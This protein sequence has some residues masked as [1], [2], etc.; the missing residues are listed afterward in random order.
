MKLPQIHRGWIFGLAAL[1][2]PAGGVYGP[3]GASTVI[4]AIAVLCLILTPRTLW[5]RTVRN[6][7]VPV[8]G[9]LILW[10]AI[11]L[12]WSPNPEAGSKLLRLTVLMIAG[13]V[14]IA[15]AIDLNSI[16]RDVFRACLMI[17]MIGGFIALAIGWAI[18][19]EFLPFI[20]PG[21]DEPGKYLSRFNRG[22]TIFSLIAWPAILVLI[23]RPP[24]AILFFV[25]V[26]GFVSQMASVAAT[27]GLA[28][29]AVIF[30]LVRIWPNF[31]PRLLLI[32]SVLY[33]AAAPVLHGLV[34]NPERVTI[35]GD[36]LE[37]EYPWFPRSAYHRILIWNF[38]A[39]K[40][41]EAPVT[42]WGFDGSKHIPGNEQ[43]LDKQESA[44]PLHPHNGPLQ[45]WLELGAVGIIIAAIFC[46]L[47][48]STIRQF[49]DRDGARETSSALFAAGFSV[50]CVSFGI[51]QSWW[52]AV[53]FLVAAFLIAARR[54]SG[55]A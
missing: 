5:Q 53:L 15:A 16:E 20:A 35:T 13:L 29:G 37:K 41:L 25:F 12:F 17:G 26:A 52:V 14:V 47:I 43:K 55:G 54:D 40:I 2:T 24:L 36:R 7:A 38:T 45:I 3:L 22:T 4:I 33:L 1:I 21:A 23:G 44:L 8:L 50:L 49:H 42:G 32:C 27:T 51:W 48:I 28:I 6:I 46:F 39:G 30:I 9:A 11:T 31:G 10:S 19:F 34:L 18:E